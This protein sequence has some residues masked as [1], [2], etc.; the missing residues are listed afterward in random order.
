MAYVP[1][2]QYAT[3]KFFCYL[4]ALNDIPSLPG[5]A[6]LLAVLLIRGGKYP[7]KSEFKDYVET[8][9]GHSDEL[10]ETEGDE[11]LFKFDIESNYLATALEK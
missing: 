3:L 9:G 1:N 6:N 10:P 7:L 5:L 2:M 4:G 8:H 11:Q